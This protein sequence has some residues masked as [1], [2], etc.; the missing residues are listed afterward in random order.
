M[1]G[2]IESEIS[3][4]LSDKQEQI[5]NRSDRAFAHLQRSIV[6][7]PDIRSK[8]LKA[9]DQGEVACEKLGSVHLLSHGI[10]GFKVNAEGERTDLVFQDILTGPLSQQ[11][12]ADGVVL[13]EWKKAK[14][15][16]DIECQFS[17]AKSQAGRYASGA[18]GGIE[19]TNYRYLV[20][21][22]KEFGPKIPDSTLEGVIYRH[23]NI[24]VE[25]SSP[26]KS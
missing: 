21:V 15:S 8:W 20:V 24:A 22:S 3:Y 14:N 9:F 17:A 7:D 25:P 6:A 2:G 12:Y 1:L 23:V 10:F 13:T 5:R 19:L 4:L 11:S 26:S 18:L 16:K